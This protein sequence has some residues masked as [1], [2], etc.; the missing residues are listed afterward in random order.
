MVRPMIDRDDITNYI[1]LGAQAAEVT[2]VV[3]D[4]LLLSPSLQRIGFGSVVSARQYSTEHWVSF[5]WEETVSVVII[6]AR[7]PFGLGS[8]QEDVLEVCEAVTNNDSAPATICV[9]LP[10]ATT[11][12]YNEQELQDYQISML[13]KGADDA[14][15]LLPDEK[16]TPHRT[17]MIK[18]RTETL[19]ARAQKWTD[20]TVEQ[21]EA[22]ARQALSDA[23]KRFVWSMAGTVLQNIPEMDPNLH[24]WCAPEGWS[25]AIGG[26]SSFT[27][28]SMLGKGSFGGVYRTQHPDHGIVAVKRV[29]RRSV[30]NASFLFA[31]DR[32]FCIMINLPKHPHVVSARQVL[33]G[34]Q[35]LYL[36]MDYAGK[37][38]LHEY[39]VQ[40]LKKEQLQSMAFPVIKN[41]MDQQAAALA[42]VHR[43][44]VCHRDIKP[45]N[46]VV[47]NDG[48]NVLLTD[49]GLSVQLCS[50][51]QPLTES[52]GSLPFCAPEV[53]ANAIEKKPYNGFAADVWSLGTNFFELLLGP[54]GVEKHLGWR[55]KTPES[56]K[57]KVTDIRRLEQFAHEIE[58]PE[59]PEE[60]FKVLRN[61]MIVLPS[62]RF[63]MN[64]IVGADGLNLDVPV[65]DRTPVPPA[66]GRPNIKRP[67]GGAG[68]GGRHLC[69]QGSSQHSC[70]GF[71]S[72]PLYREG[73]RTLG[74]QCCY[75]SPLNDGCRLGDQA[76][77]GPPMPAG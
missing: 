76:A 9:L 47:S 53:L 16:L 21:V 33:H 73:V 11:R 52:C 74:D 28:L 70:Q 4:D 37:M 8:M 50:P 22:Q 72:R 60:L 10:H 51:K 12:A 27:F 31:L 59:A 7:I 69:W 29:D 6:L 65:F 26:V 62:Q 14:V 24:E 2:C 35:G 42:H 63:S 57:Q 41:Y 77:T 54:F 44:N 39:I 17:R 66:T 18:L 32:E 61:M 19:A 75:D 43:A 30:K 46:F 15:V 3:V 5:T 48:L 36:V 45:N 58:V 20:E 34:E 23:S 40:S 68:R 67:Y 38:N 64:Q 13:S 55:P 25:G 1:D 49:F 71:D 56:L